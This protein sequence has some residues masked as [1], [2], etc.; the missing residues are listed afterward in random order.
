MFAAVEMR[1]PAKTKAVESPA[2]MQVRRKYL[3][4]TLRPHQLRSNKQG[5]E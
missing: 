4:M 3:A 1:A 5:N 2:K